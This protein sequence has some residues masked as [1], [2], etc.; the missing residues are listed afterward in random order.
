[1]VASTLSGSRWPQTRVCRLFAFTYPIYEAMKHNRIHN[2]H[3][4]FF[5]FSSL[6]SCEN[7]KIEN[8]FQRDAHN[9]RQQS[10]PTADAQKAHADCW[11][12]LDS[13]SLPSNTQCSKQWS[14]NHHWKE[15]KK[16]KNGVT[17]INLFSVALT[18]HIIHNKITCFR[19]DFYCCR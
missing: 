14:Q 17:H 13:S 18:A 11:I 9:V 1:M 7:I 4:S 5:I 16:K 8:W 19:L 15:G 10:L 12:W 2:R 6:N 3:L